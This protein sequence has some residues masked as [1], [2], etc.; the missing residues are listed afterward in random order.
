MRRS[1]LLWIV[2]F[3]AASALPVAHG[4]P[5]SAGDRAYE[6]VRVLAGMGPRVAG[7]LTE[8]RGAEYIA[9]QLRAYGYHAEVVSFPFPYFETR[10]VALELSGPQPLRLDARAL[11]YSPS[12][13]GPIRAQ[14]VAAG[15]GL[16]SDFAGTDVR[17]R[18]VLVERGDITFFEKVD[19][20]S[21]AGAVA[22]IVYNH[23][24]GLVV[25]TLGRVTSIPA[26]MISQEEGQ[27]L[28][29][30]V[31]AGP[32][33]ATLLVDTINEQRPSWNVIGSV[34][35]PGERRLVIGGHMDSV[36]GSPGANDNASGV[37]AMLEA[38]RLLRQ[39]PPRVAPEFVAFGAE[40]LG[41][42]GSFA[43]ANGDRIRGVVGMINLDMVG[44]GERLLIGNGGGDPRLVEA[45]LEAARAMGIRI[46]QRRMG[47]SDHVAF[48]RAGIPVA[49]LHR[50]DD[51]N[52]HTPQD[53][54]DKVRPEL[55][56]PVVRLAV[57]IA[58][59]GAAAASTPSRAA[60][61]LASPARR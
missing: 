40:E 37:G 20:A 12:T 59:S 42:F 21:R 18:I 29:G 39:Q 5:A 1:A 28:L 54:A 11:F 14:V 56:D 7:T 45:G 48:E 34:A 10:Q 58:R 49:F 53:T 19:N 30:M 23:Q 44:V 22:V 55:L 4:G 2:V 26:V 31:R 57:A 51:P 46:E 25:G 15:R 43:Y 16:P 17:G 35:G 33:T 36:E 6:H 60:M 27:R 38:A 32:V 3:V 41:L 47:A 52:Y 61:D 9:S 50:P 24:P 13:P 8:R